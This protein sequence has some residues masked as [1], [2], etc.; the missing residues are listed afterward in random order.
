MMRLG[1]CL[2]HADGRADLH[3]SE[4]SGEILWQNMDDLE[5]FQLEQLER[6]VAIEDDFLPDA[7]ALFA[8]NPWHMKHRSTLIEW[9]FAQRNSLGVQHQTALLA[10]N[11]L[12]R[13]LAKME[14]SAKHAVIITQ[15]CLYI[16]CKF[17]EGDL[18][19]LEDLMTLWSDGDFE[20]MLKFE[21]LIL[22]ALGW[23]LN[24]STMHT[25]ALLL[26]TGLTP[27]PDTE[28]NQIAEGLQI[29]ASLQMLFIGVK[30]SVLG[31]AIFNT[32]MKSI[33]S[34]SN[35]KR[36]HGT[37]NCMMRK[38]QIDTSAVSYTESI[39][40]TLKKRCKIIEDDRE[41]N[42]NSTA[43]KST[44]CLMDTTT[45]VFEKM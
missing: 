40:R 34:S 26:H 8:K 42:G 16:A 19:A 1:R 37:S 10:I 20:K 5:D 36:L 31:A 35:R 41:M 25:F 38:A 2:V 15:T 44:G 27:G 6:A 23:R 4:E 30:P 21:I 22:K 12:D 11:Y 3:D 39:I 18:Y 28:W 45:A 33:S 32:S 24:C 9:I 43:L 17:H 13:V 29:K 14:T 7:D